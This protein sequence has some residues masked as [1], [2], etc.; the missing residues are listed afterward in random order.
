M[1]LNTI[2]GRSTAPSQTGR[3]E[4]HLTT[5]QSLTRSFKRHLTFEDFYRCISHCVE[6]IHRAKSHGLT[7]IVAR[8]ATTHPVRLPKRKS[9]IPWFN[10]TA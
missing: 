1:R 6:A 5:L 10:L 2:A 4:P 3:T 7:S 9:K 8:S